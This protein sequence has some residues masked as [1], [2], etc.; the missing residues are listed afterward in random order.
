M[1]FSQGRSGQGE[2][3]TTR[4][5]LI[6]TLEDAVKR[7]GLFSLIEVMLPRGLTSD[8]LARFVSGFKK[9]QEKKG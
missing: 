5:E 6:A 2:R 1:K 7:R 3:I 4:R 8:T 9:A